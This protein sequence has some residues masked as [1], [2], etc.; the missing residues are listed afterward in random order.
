M[1]GG[2]TAG[3]WLL[4]PDAAKVASPSSMC[5]FVLVSD[6]L[7]SF[8]HH[9]SNCRRTCMRVAESHVPSCVTALMFVVAPCCVTG[10][11]VNPGWKV[12]SFALV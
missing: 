12:S 5:E 11:H 2:T 9:S 1:N 6:V 3:R 4:M 8:F 10:G 7:T